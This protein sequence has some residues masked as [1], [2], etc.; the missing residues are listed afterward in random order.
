MLRD[1]HSGGKC[2]H[3]MASVWKPLSPKMIEGEC[4][5]CVLLF[6][7]LQKTWEIIKGAK[8]CLSAVFR[9]W[10]K[11][12]AGVFLKLKLTSKVSNKKSDS[13]FADIK[14]R[15]FLPPFSPAGSFRHACA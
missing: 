13:K 4:E 6:L 8:A 2:H 12:A 10:R 5:T 11:S 15:S 9:F 3:R 14:N 1:R 7:S